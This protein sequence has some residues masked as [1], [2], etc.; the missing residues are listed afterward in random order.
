VPNVTIFP[1]GDLPLANVYIDYFR[2]AGSRNWSG[3]AIDLKGEGVLVIY[4]DSHPPCRVRATLMEE[5]FHLWLGH[6]PRVLRYY[7]D[8]SARTYNKAVENQAYGSGAAAL[9]PYRALRARIRAGQSSADI[10][11]HF[12]VSRD[13]VLFRSKV[14]R[15][16]SALRNGSG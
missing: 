3:M 5:F 1:H 2:R 14:T 6:P 12:E 16:Y 10:A 7:G 4:N 11:D 13:L 15:L 9:V 8:D